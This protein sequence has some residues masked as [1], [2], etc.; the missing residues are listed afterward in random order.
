MKRLFK[1]IAV[2]AVGIAASQLYAISPGSVPWILGGATVVGGATASQ[3]LEQV[4]YLG[5]YDPDN[6]VP[7]T[8]FRVRV[9]GQASFLSRMSFGSGWVPSVIADT[10]GDNVGTNATDFG[11]TTGKSPLV[12]SGASFLQYGPEGFRVVPDNNRLV[13]VMG[14]DPS[15]FFKMV[16]T[17]VA[18]L[19]GSTQPPASSRQSAIKTRLTS[20]ATELAGL[21]TITKEVTID[22]PVAPTRVISITGKLDLGNVVT[23]QTAKV[24]ATLANTGNSPLT[25]S[26]VGVPTGFTADW[27]GGS[28]AAGGKQDVSLTFAPTAAQSYSGKLSITSDSTSGSGSADI[29]GAGVSPTRDIAVKGSLAFGNVITGQIS[30]QSVEIDNTGNSALKVTKITFPAELTGSWAGGSIA[31]SA[32]QKLTVTFAPTKAET[33]S[34]SVTVDSD[35]TSGTNTVSFTGTGIAASRVIGIAGSLSFKDVAAGQVAKQSI[36]VSNSGNSALNVSG[37]TLPA[38]FGSSWT[39]GAIAASGS[40][41]LEISYSPAKAESVSGTITIASDATSGGNSIDVTATSVAATRI[42]TASGTLSFGNVVV[43]QDSDLPIT[44]ANTGNSPVT[45]SSISLP[46][47]FKADWSSGKVLPGVSQKVV[48]SFKPAKAGAVAGNLSIASDSSPAVG[49]TQVSAAGVDASRIIS[50]DGALAF[51]AVAVGKSSTAILTVGN[52]GNSPLQ[53]TEIIL[54]LGFTSDW[55]GGII[56][57]GGS[58]KV[59]VTFA[60]SAPQAMTGTL[61]VASNSTGGAKSIPISGTGTGPSP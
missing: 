54:P 31:P 29:A 48:V 13:I 4:Y 42:L 45:V 19:K 20:V 59:T 37:V 51:G 47:G 21:D 46:E 24:T 9:R 55:S 30:D 44:L 39:K 52:S 15:A 22:T 40:Q 43:G 35:S 16:D 7:P 3:R 57:P 53:V 18:S 27:K 32:T 36:T 6:R 60:P 49:D 61:E 2:S 58:Q 50:L 10:L 5:T 1:G 56:N 38:E 33:V 26:G 17:T 28:I 25:V 34:G 11:V 14:S 41:P 8:F 23:G 12:R